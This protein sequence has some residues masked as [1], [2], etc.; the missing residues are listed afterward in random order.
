[1][2]LMPF[3]FLLLFA[4]VL[5]QTPHWPA[6]PDW[7]GTSGCG[8]LVGAMTVASWLGAG[9]IAKAL[10]IQ[11]THRPEERSRLLR[12]YARWRRRHF[13]ILL[14]CYLV[15]LYYLGWGQALLVFMKEWMPSWLHYQDEVAGYQLA[16][17]MPL[18]AGMFLAWERFYGLERTAYVV[19]RDADCF[20]PKWAYL[21]V[22]IRQHFLF[23][24]PPIVLTLLQQILFGVFYKDEESSYLLYGLAFGMMI[25]A[26]LLMPIFLRLFLGLKPMPEGP[27]RDRLVGAARRLNF[28]FSNVLV[29]NTRHLVAN[30]LVTGFLPWVRYVILTDRLIDD[31]E[32]DEIEAV[33][34]HEVGH[35]KHHHLIFYLG[36]FMASFIMLGLFWSWLT[37]WITKDHVTAVL[38]MLPR[39]DREDIE[40]SLLLLGGIVK[41]ALA[42]I[43]AIVLFGFISRRCE[44]QAD[45]F[46][47]ATVSTDVFIN[48]LEKVADINGISRT[49][50]SWLH[51]S[52]AQRV[53]F[54]RTMS[55]QPARRQRFHL[56]VVAMQLAL[57]GVLGGLLWNF[58]LL[59]IWKMLAEF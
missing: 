19:L 34:G 13:F 30:A 22:Q 37:T 2:G 52:I 7:L 4:L 16:L 57:F 12:Q 56:S 20:M 42:A 21:L 25:G 40:D 46:G 28:R 6:P 54:L 44:R 10:A 49:R 35:I 23:V 58:D 26:L 41:L 36:F 14:A 51:P 47:A 38:E 29:W 33:F 53:E 48:A 50:F 24:M 39:L 17:L 1:M 59:Q 15:A 8:I 11:M 45:L 31:L 55:D 32:P 18:F 3:L 27:L 43:Y 5:L 9:V